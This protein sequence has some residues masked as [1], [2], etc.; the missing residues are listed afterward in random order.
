MSWE[1]RVQPH[2]PQISLKLSKGMT[3]LP[4]VTAWWG[5]TQNPPPRP[6]PFPL[7]III[8]VITIIIIV[9]LLLLLIIII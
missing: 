3:D 9:I 1:I 6:M 4:K 2:I 8:I 7:S 5:R